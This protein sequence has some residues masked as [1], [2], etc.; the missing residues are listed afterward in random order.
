MTAPSIKDQIVYAAIDGTM[1]Y[2]TPD[3]NNPDFDNVKTVSNDN[4][5]WKAGE[6]IGKY[7]GIKETAGGITWYQLEVLMYSKNRFL[8]LNGYK[9]SKTKVNGS[10]NPRVIFT[11]FK[12]TEL[13]TIKVIS[14]EAAAAQKKEKEDADLLALMKAYLDK[15]QAT[16]TPKKSFFGSIFGPTIAED[17]TVENNNIAAIVSIIVILVLSIVGLV[18]IRRRKTTSQQTAVTIVRKNGKNYIVNNKKNYK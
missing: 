8:G 3:S 15:N 11:W 6:I 7:R 1:P 2:E 16:A 9:W 13:D 5:T 4:I 12:E 17:G 18:V 10:Y 14:T